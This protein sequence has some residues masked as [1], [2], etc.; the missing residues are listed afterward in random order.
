MKKPNCNAIRRSIWISVCF[1][2]LSMPLF[3][4]EEEPL[5]KE[6]RFAKQGT[7]STG[8]RGLF[9]VPS[10]ETLSKGQFSFGTAWSSV[11]R[12]PQDISIN[13]MPLYFSYGVLG[14]LTV[15]TAWEPQKQV[16]ARNSSQPGFYNTLPFA[17]PGFHRGSGDTLI[18][19]KYR[20]QRRRDNIGG[21]AVR[22]V[23]KLP[24]ADP[25]KGLGTGATDVGVDLIFTSKLPWQFVMH[26]SMGYTSLGDAT[27]PSV[28]R[29]KN[30][31]VAGFGAAW[32][33]AG[34]NVMGGAV[35]GIAEYS[36]TSFIGGSSF[37]PSIQSPTD[38]T[39]GL[40]YLFRTGITMDAGYRNNTGFDTRSG[41]GN[42]GSHRQGFTVSIGYTKPGPPTAGTGNH[43]PI[44]A[45]D[46]DRTEIAAGGTAVITAE[47]FDQDNDKLTYSWSTTGGQI[48]GSGEKVV[49]S[50]AG[51][52][53]GKYTVRVSA[54]D[55]RG[56]VADSL[57]EITVQ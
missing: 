25:V 56:G 24:S 10:A 47:G 57:I 41:T 20:L 29:L 45:L 48:T 54:R 43:F 52:P 2:L 32:P 51:V 18:M 17:E 3:A 30:Q 16:N 11:S 13:S 19:A 40:R 37:N 28:V 21:M 55:G 7:T 38:V 31:T 14:R 35:Q 6:T 36:T 44:V 50:A 12:T 15:T 39:F 46:A 4:Q 26:S 9:T 42:P 27:S 23:V 1:L 34:I 22:G 53:G 33:V 49:F 5:S 8:D